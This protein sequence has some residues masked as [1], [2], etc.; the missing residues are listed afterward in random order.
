MKFHTCHSG[1]VHARSIG[2]DCCGREMEFA[3]FGASVHNGVQMCVGSQ[4]W[5]VCSMCFHMRDK[6]IHGSAQLQERTHAHS[7]STMRWDLL[8]MAETAELVIQEFSPPASIP[9]QRALPALSVFGL[10]VFQDLAFPFQNAPHREQ[11]SCT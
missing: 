8:R 1:C 7:Q 5:Q 10:L 9:S 11:C 4:P 6:F 3:P 2:L